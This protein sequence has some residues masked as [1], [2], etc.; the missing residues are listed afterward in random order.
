MAQIDVLAIDEL[1]EVAVH[2]VE[3]RA[4]TAESGA[5]SWMHVE[6]D[7]TDDDEAAEITE[8]VQRVSW[9]EMA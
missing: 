6:I 4:G 5:E 3:P 1:Q 2:V 7:R 9:E 8:G